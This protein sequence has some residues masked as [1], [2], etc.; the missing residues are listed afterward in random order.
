MRFVYGTRI[1]LEGNCLRLVGGV[2]LVGFVKRKGHFRAAGAAAPGGTSGLI[3][4]NR[5][6]PQDNGFFGAYPGE[7]F[8]CGGVKTSG[9]LLRDNFRRG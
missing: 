4:V 2:G 7:L 3:R 8:V 9:L 5:P 6:D 1:L